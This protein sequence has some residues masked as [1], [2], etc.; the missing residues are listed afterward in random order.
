MNQTLA[1]RTWHTGTAKKLGI[2]LRLRGESI[3]LLPRP[4]HSVEQNAHRRKKGCAGYTSWTGNKSS[5]GP[6]AAQLWMSLKI[7]PPPPSVP[8]E[9]G[10]GEQL[11]EQRDGHL[12]ADLWL[13]TPAERVQEGICL[14]VTPDSRWGV[15]LLCFILSFPNESLHILHCTA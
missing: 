5:L 11:V 15:S 1:A 12:G 8:I 6:H 7:H 13:K 3:R 14:E 4:G 2:V 10:P 9:P